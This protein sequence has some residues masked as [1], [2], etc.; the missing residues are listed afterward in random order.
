MVDCGQLNTVVSVN[1]GSFTA[2]FMIQTTLSL[3][4]TLLLLLAY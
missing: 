1:V 2:R 3:N 4:C